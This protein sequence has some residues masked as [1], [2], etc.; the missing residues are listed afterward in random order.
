MDITDQRVRQA[1]DHFHFLVP[2]DRQS[3]HMIQVDTVLFVQVNLFCREICEAVEAWLLRVAGD[4]A[5]QAS[6][7]SL[8]KIEIMGDSKANDAETVI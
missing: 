3:Y 2:P 5:I 8:P 1:L 6:I 4:A 7:D